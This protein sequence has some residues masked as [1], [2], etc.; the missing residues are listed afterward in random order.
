MAE[1][2]QVSSSVEQPTEQGNQTQTPIEQTENWQEKYKSLETEHYKTKAD[3]EQAMRIVQNTEQFFNSDKDAYSRLDAWINGKTVSPVANEKPAVPSGKESQF[4]P[5]AYKREIEELV[6][7]RVSGSMDIVTSIQAKEEKSQLQS[8]YAWLDD[9]K[10]KEFE[11]KFESEVKAKADELVSMGV[12]PKKAY[13]NAI[14]KYAALSQEDLLFKFMRD[15]VLANAAKAGRA[16]AQLPHGMN[17]K[18]GNAAGPEP[19]LLEQAKK[20]YIAV[21]GNADATAKMMTEFAPQLGMT[22][23]QLYTKINNELQGA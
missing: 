6:E 18:I 19:A 3:Y 22:A 5:E 4:D 11:N 9:N 16:T 8:K 13:D 23:H 12:P 20:A 14:A 17:G 21:E 7:S 1:E 15:E 2:S 10:Y